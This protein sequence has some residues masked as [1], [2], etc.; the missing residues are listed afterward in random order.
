[1]PRVAV[2]L[3]VIFVVALGITFATFFFFPSPASQSQKIIDRP[4]GNPALYV[5][6]D[7]GLNWEE[8]DASGG[9]VPL[10]FAIQ[11]NESSQIY[12]GTKG[13]GLWVSDDAGK[14]F[15]RA[16]DSSGALDP[17]ADIYAI[18]QNASGDTV[19]LA[20]YEKNFGKLIRL[21]REGAEEIYSTPLPRYG[22]FGVVVDPRDERHINIASGDGGFFET[23]DGGKSWEVISRTAEGLV[24]LAKNSASPGKLWAVGNKGTFYASDSGGRV[25]RE[26]KTIHIE[27]GKTAKKIYQIAY[28]PARRSVLAGSDYGFIET[29]NDGE[30]WSAFRTIVPPDSLPITTI[31]SH[32]RFAEVLWMAADRQIYRTDDGGVTWT[33]GIFPQTLSTVNISLLQ[34][35]ENNPKKIYAGLSR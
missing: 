7:G 9:L 1:M 8:L 19:Y 27:G 11:A 16:Q 25:W 35:D 5:S 17:K 14:T 32:P 34:V 24:L 20:T 6:N 22:I 2:I 30:S 10:S 23:V 12:L 3:L 29:T 31:A 18:A 13:E 4:K 26:Y 21:R 33:R 28:N 15:K